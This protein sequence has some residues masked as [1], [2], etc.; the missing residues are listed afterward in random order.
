[1]P[2]IWRWRDGRLTVLERQPHGEYI[3]RQKSLAL[4]NFPLEDLSIALGGY[5][6]TDP[7]R[8]VAQFRSRVR[9][10]RRA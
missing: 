6:P 5:P 7:A 3:E 8:A 1:V 9:V 4:P 10:Q 2:E